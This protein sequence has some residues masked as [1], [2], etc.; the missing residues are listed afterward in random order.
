MKGT[1][2]DSKKDRIKYRVRQQHLSTICCI[3][4]LRHVSPEVLVL[5]H[6]HRTSYLMPVFVS[7][8]FHVKRE[9]PNMVPHRCIRLDLPGWIYPSTMWKVKCYFS[10]YTI[11]TL[12]WWIKIRALSF[13]VGKIFH[14]W[15]K[16][17][18]YIFI[19]IYKEN[20]CFIILKIAVNSFIFSYFLNHSH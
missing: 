3:G 17:N 14:L 5:L 8:S 7:R 20:A 6:N 4:K 16:K 12:T 1:A 15:R 9:K 11:S 10:D 18:I 13:L 2:C 19:Y